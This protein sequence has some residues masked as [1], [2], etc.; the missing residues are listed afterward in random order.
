MTGRYR[1][2]DGKFTKISDHGRAPAD[3]PFSAKQTFNAGGGVQS[4]L[5]G[6]TYY[7]VRSYED[8]VKRAGCKIDGN[9]TVIE[10][11]KKEIQGDFNVREELTKVTHQVLSK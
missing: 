2:I 3:R 8:S 4:P 11:P 9:D 5:D 10:A 7:D 6:K 1:F